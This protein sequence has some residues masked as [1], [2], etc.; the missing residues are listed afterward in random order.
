MEQKRIKSVGLF[1]LYSFTYASSLS[2]LLLAALG[3]DNDII[4]L[5]Q[6]LV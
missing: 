1:Y 4:L 3:S 6:G 2:G 5:V